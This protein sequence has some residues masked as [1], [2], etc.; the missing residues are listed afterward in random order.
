[1]LVCTVLPAFPLTGCGWSSGGLDSSLVAATLTK[2][3]KEDQLQYPLQTFSIGT[4]DSPDLLA[5]R[6]VGSS[7][8]L[9]PSKGTNVE[10]DVCIHQV[11]AHIGSEHHEVTFS[12]EEGIRVVED[13]IYHLE[14]YDI[15][16]LRASIRE[17]A[18]FSCSHGNARCN[19]NG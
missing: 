10:R 5:A 12:I 18:R 16:T 15:T 14:T 6:K 9:L 19:D 13:V 2:L 17:C 11:A 1:M 7:R 4:E 8:D 3:A